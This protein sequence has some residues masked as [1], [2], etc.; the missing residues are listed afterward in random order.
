MKR[1]HVEVPTDT[2]NFGILGA[3]EGMRSGP[4]HID[5]RYLPPIPRHTP[6]GNADERRQMLLLGGSI[7]ISM[8]LL[9]IRALG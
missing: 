3:G 6:D 7:A 1:S 2:G 5:A 9:L 8:I 4:W